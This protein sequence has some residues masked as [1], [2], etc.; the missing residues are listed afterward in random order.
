MTAMKAADPNAQLGVPWAFDGTVGG[1]SV[2]DNNIWNDTVLGAD[3][4][5]IGF[6]DTHW[7][8]FGFGGN[9]G[10]GGNPTD[11][12]VIQSVTQIPVRV[13]PRSGPTLNE[14]APGREGHRRRDRRQLPGRPTCRAP[15]PARCSPRATRSSGW[16]RARR[17]STGG[18]WTRTRT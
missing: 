18:R 13:R 1:A 11:Q 9:A 14:Y 10:A 12:T 3:A 2:G 5:Y 8:P 6:V 17:A 16:R 4:Q 15:P 7:Y